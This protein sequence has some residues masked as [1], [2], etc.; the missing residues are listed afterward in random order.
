MTHREQI[1]YRDGVVITFFSAGT[2]MS[3]FWVT[4]R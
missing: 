3:P 1:G 4:E 2:K